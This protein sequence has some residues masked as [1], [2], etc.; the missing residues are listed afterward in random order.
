MSE[1][2]PPTDKAERLH[3]SVWV[4]SAPAR[5]RMRTLVKYMSIPKYRQDENLTQIHTCQYPNT[6]RYRHR[7]GTLG[8]CYDRKCS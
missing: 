8:C 4:G 2:K 3:V 1:M 5:S 7:Y 6:D